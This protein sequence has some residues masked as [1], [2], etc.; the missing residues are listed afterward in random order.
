MLWAERV[1]AAAADLTG[2]TAAVLILIAEGRNLVG[3]HG[4]PE[5]VIA[6]GRERALAS[7]PALKRWVELGGNA[8]CHD[9]VFPD[10]EVDSPLFHEVMKPHDLL[11]GAAVAANLRSAPSILVVFRSGEASPDFQVRAMWLLSLVQPLLAAAADRGARNPAAAQGAA[12]LPTPAE[13]RARFGLTPRQ[14]EVALLLAR[15][16]TIRQVAVALSISPHTARHHAEAVLRGLRVHSK[17]EVAAVLLGLG[18]HDAGD[19]PA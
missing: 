8:C 11:N 19:E 4:V 15:G 1:A 3:G 2:G 14:A 9:L 6:Q 7:E 5:R 18:R 16:Q 17:A 13:V 12:P 10:G